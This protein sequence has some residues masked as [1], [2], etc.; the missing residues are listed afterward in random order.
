MSTLPATVVHRRLLIELN[1]AYLLCV[2]LGIAGILTA[3]MTLQYANHELPC[4]LCLL[5]RVA[6]FGVCF[7][8]LQNFR[9]GFS[10]RNTGYSLLFTVLLLV[11]SVRQSLLDIYP[12]PGH[13]YIGSAIFGIHMPVW[14]IIIALTLLT[15]YAVKLAILGGDEFLRDADVGSYAH[16]AVGGHH[17]A[18]R[19]RTPGDQ[20]RLRRAAVWTR[21]VPH[22]RLQAVGRLTRAC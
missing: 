10:Y 9:H 8:V 1:F 12:R 11:I 15:A 6:L 17:R 18:V 20:L 14:S 3:A 16:Q 13:A 4:P 21:R 7:G 19:D 2:V 22:V 5:E